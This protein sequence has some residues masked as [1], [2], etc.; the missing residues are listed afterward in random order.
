ME[1]QIDLKHMKKAEKKALRLAVVTS[2][3]GGYV[4]QSRLHHLPHRSIN[5][6]GVEADVEGSQDERTGKSNTGGARRP[7]HGSMSDVDTGS[8]RKVAG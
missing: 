2:L 7:P 8:G 3:M 1:G 6:S 5:G 4:S